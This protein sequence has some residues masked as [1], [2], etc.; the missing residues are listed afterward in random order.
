VAGTDLQPFTIRQ[1]ESDLFI[2]AE[3]D[4]RRAAASSLRKARSELRAW[5][6]QHPAF[7]TA[8]EP[9]PL[10][11]EAPEIVRRMCRA[12]AAAG[13][14]PMAAVAGA[15][16]EW[17]GRSLMELS[18]EVIVE[19]GG[20]IFLR[21]RRGRVVSIFAGES[22]LSQRVGLLVPARSTPIGVCTS[23][24]TVGPSLSFGVADAAVVASPDTALAD[25]VATACANRVRDDAD[26]RDAVDFA[27]Q[28]QGVVQVVVVK[29]VTV[30]AWG[31]FELVN[32]G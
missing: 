9:V 21:S 19:N 6:R 12:A 4:L 18:A 26:V 17:V 15:I 11:A 24:G 23:S 25:A 29:H 7:A 1:G 27:R 14:G 3:G 32:L 28:V 2:R 16:A 30:G 5:M 10:D 20:D 22:P 8:L 31:Q 13:V